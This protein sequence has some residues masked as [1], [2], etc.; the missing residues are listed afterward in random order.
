[1]FSQH[2]PSIVSAAGVMV[3]DPGVTGA[4]NV[5]KDDGVFAT[6][7]LDRNM[8]CARKLHI[9][10]AQPP[11]QGVEVVTLFFCNQ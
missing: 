5:V 10:D 11:P 9:L 7:G 3:T 8:M 6:P 2:L 4:R 1:M